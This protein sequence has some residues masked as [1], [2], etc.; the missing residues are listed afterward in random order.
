M[1]VQL[2]IKVHLTF[3]CSGFPPPVTASYHPYIGS[4]QSVPDLCHVL[5]L[6]II[7]GL[8]NYLCFIVSQRLVKSRSETKNWTMSVCVL[9]LVRQL[10]LIALE[11]VDCTFVYGQDVQPTCANRNVFLASAPPLRFGGRLKIYYSPY[12]RKLIV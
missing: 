12:G 11:L 4:S 7:L 10:T 5:Q 8:L 9:C 2:L 6:S 1:S 3:L